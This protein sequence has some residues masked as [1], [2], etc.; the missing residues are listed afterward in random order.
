MVS[1]DLASC[2]IKAQL[3][4]LINYIPFWTRSSDSSLM[5]AQVT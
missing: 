2:L 4:L 1:L 3:G 5:W